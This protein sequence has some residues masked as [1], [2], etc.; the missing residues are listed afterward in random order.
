MSLTFP[1]RS[2]SFDDATN[3]VRFLGYDGVFEVPFTV[4]A[5]ALAT[6]SSTE[7]TEAEYLAAFDAARGSILDIAREIYS[8]SRRTTYVLTAGDFR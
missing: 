7:L 5:D 6:S 8:A 1:N 3:A 4:E 2:R